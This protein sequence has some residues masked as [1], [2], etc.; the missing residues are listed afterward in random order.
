MNSKRLLPFVAVV[1]LATALV[2]AV[3]EN[4]SFP[5]AE[6]SP[7]IVD[8]AAIS[9]RPAPVDA[10]YYRAHRIVDL[11]AVTAHPAAADQAMFLAGA[12]LEASLACRC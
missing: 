6:A 2:P 11:P 3:M 12:A 4:L 8:L 10:A 5:V 7:R 1:L 9:V